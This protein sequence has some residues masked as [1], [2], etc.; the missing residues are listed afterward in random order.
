MLI[1]FMF[2]FL[3]QNSLCCLCLS[4][5]LHNNRSWFNVD[6]YHGITM[7]MDILII[8]KHYLMM[9]VLFIP[10]F[11]KSKYSPSKYKEPYHIPILISCKSL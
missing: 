5:R 1:L 11:Q 6:H 4:G 8:A 2:T 10:H 3:H 9:I 7:A